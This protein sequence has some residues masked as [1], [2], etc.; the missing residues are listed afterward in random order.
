MDRRL[1]DHA[2]LQHDLKNSVNIVLGFCNMLQHTEPLTP[3]QARYLDRIKKAAETIAR[4]VEKD[5]GPSSLAS[6]G[7]ATGSGA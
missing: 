4:R 7:R 5:P 1:D 3:D 6:S 2:A